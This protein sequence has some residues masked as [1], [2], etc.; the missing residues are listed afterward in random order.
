MLYRLV[1][2]LMTLA[3]RIFY[4]KI[5]FLNSQNIPA[6]GPAILIANHPGS[7]MDAALLGLLV[8]RPIHFF[9]RGDIFKNRLIHRI[10]NALH[11]H[12]I[13]HHQYNR[14]SLGVNDDSFEI[15]LKLLQKGELVLFFPEGFSHVE[16]FLLPFKKGTFRLAFQALEKNQH[17]SLPIVPVGFHYSHPTELF[18]TVWVKAG[19]PVE[20][21]D[22]YIAY[23]SNTAQAVR[24]LTDTTYESIKEL[25][26]QVPASYSNELFQLLA[27]LR[28]DSRYQMA[29]PAKQWHL[30]KKI[31]LDFM[32]IHEMLL[33]TYRSYKH[34]LKQ[35]QIKEEGVLPTN[36][37]SLSK[38]KKLLC[39]F[40]A[41]PGFLLHAPPLFIAKWI[42]DTKVTRIDFYAWILVA[43][44]ALLDSCWTLLIFLV[45]TVVHSLL[46]GMFFFV[47]S[48]FLGW[49]TWKCVP[50]LIRHRKEQQLKNIPESTLQQIRVKHE[51]LVSS[52]RSYLF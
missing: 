31:S 44:A 49:I 24:K 5:H 43:A 9:A 26:I 7:L 18:S 1:K 3:T 51:E 52:I 41:V 15:A 28:T 46:A 38:Q 50:S 25:T 29:D 11:M 48:I 16:Y 35:H 30:E 45:L 39:R 22:F 20:T 14:S 47:T 2:L 34:L 27:I 21:T 8:N 37:N 19:P 6:T 33:E 10:L 12:P 17:I 4:R 42:A 36:S 32:R 40:L 23:Q 13:H